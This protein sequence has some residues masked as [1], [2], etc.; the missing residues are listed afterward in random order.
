MKQTS[1]TP[2]ELANMVAGNV[3]KSSPFSGKDM[4]QHERTLGPVGPVGPVDWTDMFLRPVR[5]RLNDAS[6]VEPSGFIRRSGTSIWWPSPRDRWIFNDF[7]V[8]PT[9]GQYPKRSFGPPNAY[10]PISSLN[11]LN[12]WHLLELGFYNVLYYS[13]WHVSAIYDTLP[14]LSFLLAS[15]SEQSGLADGPAGVQIEFRD[16]LV[17]ATSR[18]LED[19]LHF[20][21]VAR[22]KAWIWAETRENPWKIHGKSMEHQFTSRICYFRIGHSYHSCQQTAG[23][24]ALLPAYAGET[25]EGGHSLK[26]PVGKGQIALERNH[27]LHWRL[28]VFFAFLD[29]DGGDMS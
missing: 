21:H 5:I 1:R 24:Y 6:C 26:S 4:K 29:L 9:K 19:R 28:L 27:L 13:K 3:P 16:D 23:R 7:S 8:S 12:E 11:I 25:L 18:N 15:G 10:P 20:C 2:P 17:P 22:S 14:R